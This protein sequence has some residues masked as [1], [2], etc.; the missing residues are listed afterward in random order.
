MLQEIPLSLY[1]MLSYSK[2]V[3]QRLHSVVHVQIFFALITLLFISEMGGV[4]WVTEP[5]ITSCYEINSEF[6]IV[7]TESDFSLYGV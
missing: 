7:N 1:C 4:K 6:M 3:V 2:S 5:H